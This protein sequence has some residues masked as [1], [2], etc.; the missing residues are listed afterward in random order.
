[1]WKRLALI[2][3]ALRGDLKRLWR[4]LRHPRSPAWLKL[5]V[6]ALVLYLFMP[7]DFLPDFIPFVGAVDDV[8]ILTLG[9]KWLL[10]QLP[11]ALRREIDAPPA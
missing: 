11:A 1:M 3:A 9:I 10:G 8:L 4:A 7:I 6:A 2:W 5:G